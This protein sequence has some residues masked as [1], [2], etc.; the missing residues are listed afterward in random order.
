MVFVALGCAW[1][2]SARIGGKSLAWGWILA[3]A[4]GIG[5]AWEAQASRQAWSTGMRLWAAAYGDAE[6]RNMVP[7]LNY[8]AELAA[9]GNRDAAKKIAVEYAQSQPKGFDACRIDAMAD[10]H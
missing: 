3:A 4:I 2:G 7:T 10:G 8:V 5:N 1:L 6:H 9:S